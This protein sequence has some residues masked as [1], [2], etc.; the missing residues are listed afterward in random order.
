MVVDK[1][2]I[3][4]NKEADAAQYFQNKN[5]FA[6]FVNLLHTNNLDDKKSAD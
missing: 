6:K 3:E 4:G 2:N 1:F 5:G